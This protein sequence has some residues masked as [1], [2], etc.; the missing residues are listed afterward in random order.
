MGT[1]HIRGN[2]PVQQALAERPHS[3][4]LAHGNVLHESSVVPGIRH[5]DVEAGD[6][7]R[8]D[9]GR[10]KERGS[11]GK[12]RRTWALYCARERRNLTGQLG[13]NRRRTC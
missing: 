12:T 1:H 13:A 10:M 5:R 6:E 8:G 7:R 3:L 11:A 9:G 4:V 2:E